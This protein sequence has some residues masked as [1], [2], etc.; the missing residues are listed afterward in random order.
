M[1]LTVVMPTFN[2]AGLLEEN[3]SSLLESRHHFELLIVDDG[4][5][6][7]TFSLAKSFR[8][9]RVTYFRHEVNHGYGKSL[10]DGIERAKNS[11]IFLCEDDAF[12]LNPDEFFEV[13]AAIASIG[14]FDWIDW[15][16]VRETNFGAN[17][18]M[19]NV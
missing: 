1:D 7:K 18:V 2:R 19:V 12:I 14:M 5:T 9:P 17:L 8:D 3:V 11:Q 13:P 6:D 15:R 4:S 16:I 10:N